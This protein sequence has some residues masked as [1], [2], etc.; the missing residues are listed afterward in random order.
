[1]SENNFTTGRL[2]GFIRSVVGNP[3]DLTTEDKANIVAAMNEL[4]E[5]ISEREPMVRFGATPVYSTTLAEDTSVGGGDS[6]TITS[7]MMGG[8]YKSLWARIALPSAASGNCYCNF[9]WSA[10][11]SISGVLR[12]SS[13]YGMCFTQ[14]NSGGV[15]T[16]SAG[17]D[18]LGGSKAVYTVQPYPAFPSADFSKIVISL[19]SALTLPAGTQITIYGAQEV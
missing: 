5:D 4:G 12:T 8:S 6:L 17:S 11:Q 7:E 18:V 16:F 19:S 14:W 1:M 2:L 13:L 10:T 9:Y 3:A 15:T